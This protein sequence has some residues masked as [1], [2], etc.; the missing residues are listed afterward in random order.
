MNNNGFIIE[1]S[2]ISDRKSIKLVEPFIANIKNDY[3]IADEKYYNIL[4]AVTEAVNN[5]IIHG[6][7][8]C[9]SKFVNLQLEIENSFLIISVQDQGS[10]FDPEKVADPRE[11]ENLF[12]TG[13]RGVF[14]IKELSDD[15]EVS[16]NSCGGKIVMKFKIF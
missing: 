10:G 6:N 7:K 1:K 13:G 14:L 8:C 3:N 9:C 16:S 15:I 2:F 12:K 11:P 4:I 5:A